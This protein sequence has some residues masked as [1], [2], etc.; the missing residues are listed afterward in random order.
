MALCGTASH[1]YS[2]ILWYSFILVVN[3]STARRSGSCI[4]LRQPRVFVALFPVSMVFW[5]FFEYLNRYV[6]N[7]YYVG[8][9]D[10]GVVGY[11]FFASI[12]FATV[13][14]AVASV[15]EWLRTFPIVDHSFSNYPIVADK[16]IDRTAWPI[17]AIA[18]TGLFLFGIY[19]DYLYPLIWLSPFFVTLSLYRIL[20]GPDVSHALLGRLSK[21][22]FSWSLSALI[23]GFFWEMWNTY[24]F[25]KWIYSVPFAHRFQ[26]FEMPLLGYAGY[27]PFGLE[28]AVM[29]Y[30]IVGAES[31]P[32]VAFGRVRASTTNS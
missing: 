15:Q 2:F 3:A 12:S 17:L 23:C 27:L 11:V 19:P 24:S 14:P 21:N 10:F 32:K 7:W 4:M 31:D 30:A 29:V 18:G 9:E 5:W 8:I 25:A 20:M 6:Q 28:C 26:I 16:W 1:V 13:L 22:M